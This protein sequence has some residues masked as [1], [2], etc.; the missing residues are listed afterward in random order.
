MKLLSPLKNI[1]MRVPANTNKKTLKV[2]FKI[3]KI[4]IVKA[5]IPTVS[6]TCF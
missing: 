5:N 3:N 4:I 1:A 2:A 6:H